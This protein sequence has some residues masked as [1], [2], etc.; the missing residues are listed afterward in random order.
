MPLFV[1][2][3]WLIVV[4]ILLCLPG[5]EFPKISWLNK[6]WFDKW[7]H[8]GLFFALTAIWCLYFSG[9]KTETG[10][11]RKIFTRLA[12]LSFVYGMTMEVIQHY[13]IPLRSFDVG[14]ILAD[15]AGSLGG[16]LYSLSKFL[17]K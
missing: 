10:K 16:F 11:R 12:I 7:V 2:I 4:T 6:I 5:N 13:F 8:L 3:T 15:G 1:A 17:N 14:D 9:K